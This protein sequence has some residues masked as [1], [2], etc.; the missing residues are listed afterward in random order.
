MVYIITNVS[1]D[2]LSQKL[3]THDLHTPELFNVQQL[4]LNPRAR[5]TKKAEFALKQLKCEH[6]FSS[7]SFL[8]AGDKFLAMRVSRPG[9]R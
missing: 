1:S 6:R 7:A 3:P 2:F 4:S 9:R 5:L 8:M